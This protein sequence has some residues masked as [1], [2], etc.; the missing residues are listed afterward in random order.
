[1]NGEIVMKNYIDLVWDAVCRGE[2]LFMG[3]RAGG[4]RW[5]EP[6]SGGNVLALAPHPDDPD[7]VAV[8]LK[9]FHTAGCR[10]RYAVTGR[11]HGGVTDSYACEAAKTRGDSPTDLKACKTSLRRRE[12]TASA[13][14]AGI[15]DGEV[16]FVDPSAEDDSGDMLHSLANARLIRRLLR[17]QDPDI[18]LM[19]HGADTNSGHVALYH[20]FGELAAP[21]AVERERP[22]L[23]LF[24]RDPKTTAIEQQLV[25]PFNEEAARWKASLL[26]CH[27]SQQQRGIEVRGYG[28]DERI[29]KLNRATQAELRSKVIEPWKEDCLYAE[30]FQVELFG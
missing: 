8:T 12:Q 16:V 22:L 26:R 7:A 4:R 3:A 17:E 24:A 13:Q 11:A 18:V 15:V 23:A 2:F 25:V 1:L 20:L 9:L 19:P 29:L 28:L 6:P 10:V 27:D 30:S 21:L 5:I 14:M